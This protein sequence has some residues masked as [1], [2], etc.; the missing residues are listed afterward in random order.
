MLHPV[1]EWCTSCCLMFQY[2]LAKLDRLTMD[3]LSMYVPWI[4]T[5]SLMS[6]DE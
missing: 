2:R 5:S 4:P 6:Y 1:T 3:G